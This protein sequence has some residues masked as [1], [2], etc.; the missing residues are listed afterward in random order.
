MIYKCECCGNLINTEELCCQETYSQSI[1]DIAENFTLDNSMD[2]KQVSLEDYR[3]KWVVL[4]FFPQCFTGVCASEV[5]EFNKRIK[6]FSDLNCQPIG[7]NTDSI[8]TQKAWA[9]TLGGCSYPLLADYN[10]EVSAS[11]GVLTEKGFANRGLFI[12]DEEGKIRYKVEHE[13]AIGR[14]VNETLRVLRALQ[15][16]GACAVDWNFGDENM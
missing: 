8:H 2:G 6:E 14:S 4:F 10:K 3:G 13:P 5:V 1:G 11:Y 12:I 7:V 9:D 16:K 15:S